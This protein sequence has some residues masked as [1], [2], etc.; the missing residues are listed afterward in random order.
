MHKNIT[1]A[2]GQD[3]TLHVNGALRCSFR[4]LICPLL[5]P[6]N[7]IKHCIDSRF[8]VRQNRIPGCMCSV[9]THTLHTLYLT[10]RKGLLLSKLTVV[11]MFIRMVQFLPNNSRSCTFTPCPL[12]AIAKA[13]QGRKKISILLLLCHSH[14]MLLLVKD[15]GNSV[16]RLHNLYHKPLAKCNWF[17]EKR[18]RIISLNG[19]HSLIFKGLFYYLHQAM[20]FKLLTHNGNCKQV[21][22]A[23]TFE[24]LRSLPTLCRLCLMWAK[25]ICRFVIV[26]KMDCVFFE[27][28]T[29][30]LKLFVSLHDKTYICNYYL[31]DFI[32]K[33]YSNVDSGITNWPVLVLSW[34]F[35]NSY[36]RGTCKLRYDH[37]VPNILKF[38]T[39]FFCGAAAQIRPSPPVLEVSTSHAIRHSRP[40]G[41]LRTSDQLVAEADTTQQTQ[42]KNIQAFSG[43]RTRNPSNQAAA[44]LR[45]R[46]HGHRKILRYTFRAIVSTLKLTIE[47]NTTSPSFVHIWH[48]WHIWHIQ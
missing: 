35:P 16:Y 11:K 37:F 4:A 36:R 13:N 10:L 22:H 6:C 15:T 41:L 18:R 3:S 20:C 46:P 21:Q 47:Y 30:F 34:N 32:I 42:E 38:V 40:V 39:E 23:V 17:S 2:L 1:Q 24:R 26:N 43:I 25:Q 8:K 27:V 7:I 31:L 19:I 29:E 5:Q 48:I 9:D 44:D 28:K 33:N 45:L 14:E 12:L